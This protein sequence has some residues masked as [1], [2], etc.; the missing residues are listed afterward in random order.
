MEVL[1]FIGGIIGLIVLIMILL[2]PLK[3]W[4]IDG[5]MDE[6]IDLLKKEK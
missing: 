5:K 1:Y 2:A 3:L 6:I 4:S